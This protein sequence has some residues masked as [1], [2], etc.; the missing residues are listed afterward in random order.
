MP[1]ETAPSV[2]AELPEGHRNA[3]I[4]LAADTDCPLELVARTYR[5]ELTELQAD[6]RITQYL[7]V[8]ATRRARERLRP[9]R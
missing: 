8:I 2:L 4:G 9:H 6:A 7:P 5:S 3:I 1:S